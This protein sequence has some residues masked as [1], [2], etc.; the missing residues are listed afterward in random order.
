MAQEF[1]N[2][3]ALNAMWKMYRPHTT[4]VGDGFRSGSNVMPFSL[5][6]NKG[7]KV[8]NLVTNFQYANTT[9]SNLLSIPGPAGPQYVNL[10]LLGVTS[11]FRIRQNG[12]TKY[13]EYVVP[14]IEP[15][16][17]QLDCVRTKSTGVGYSF[18][19]LTANKI[20]VSGY[21][22][23]DRQVT[24]SAYSQTTDFIPAGAL[25]KI[26]SIFIDKVGTGNF[27]FRTRQNIGAQ[28]YNYG[29]NPNLNSYMHG[30]RSITSY[31]NTPPQYNF[32]NLSA[33]NDFTMVNAPIS[34][35]LVKTN[36]NA[37]NM[38]EYNNVVSN[39][40]TNLGFGTFFT[41]MLQNL[42][43]SQGVEAN[44]FDPDKARAIMGWV[45][46]SDGWTGWGGEL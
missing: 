30:G 15:V 35:A 31:V 27:I 36:P 16:T 45:P 22:M 39:G 25:T 20:I 19:G 33:R 28:Y 40:N 44:S 38:N 18:S 37:Q 46:N 24:Y 14:L 6:T 17:Q 32:A 5:G 26:T 10:N 9:R 2:I 7:V 42:P 29:Q 34:Q 23:Y 43:T 4:S 1:T 11:S 3:Q 41:Q 21:D 8:G 13:I 12:R